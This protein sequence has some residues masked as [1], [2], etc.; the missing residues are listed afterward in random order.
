MSAVAGD[1]RVDAGVSVRR[2]YGCRWLQNV[3]GAPV[4]VALSD[5]RLCAADRPCR[6]CR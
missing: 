2:I 1:I 6:Q 5:T 4:T 3:V